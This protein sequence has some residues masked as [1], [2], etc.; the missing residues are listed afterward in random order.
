MVEFTPGERAAHPINLVIDAAGADY[1]TLS[2]P[3]KR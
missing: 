2:K 3:L 1:Q